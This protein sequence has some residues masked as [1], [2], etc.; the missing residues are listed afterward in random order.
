MRFSI[1]ISKE[2]MERLCALA[3]LER[4]RPGDQAAWM[5][6]GILTQLEKQKHSRDILV[7]AHDGSD[8]HPEYLS[9]LVGP[10]PA[11]VAAQAQGRRM[12]WD[13]NGRPQ[14]YET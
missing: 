8:A 13:A 6:E 4:R 14:V 3:T 12:R 5:L 10:E 1:T 9:R 7:T 11:E 2:A